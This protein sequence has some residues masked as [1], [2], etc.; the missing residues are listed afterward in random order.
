MWGVHRAY[1][2]SWE[3]CVENVR[4]MV[5]PI[6]HPGTLAPAPALPLHAVVQDPSRASM[7]TSEI[8]F[9]TDR[10]LKMLVPTG[11]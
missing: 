3:G 1:S 7:S 5:E 8:R 6:E 11:A 10:G 9:Q 2:M 4:Q